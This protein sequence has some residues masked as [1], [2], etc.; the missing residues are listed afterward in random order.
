[1]SASGTFLGCMLAGAGLFFKVEQFTLL[2]NMLA[3]NKILQCWFNQFCIN[4][5]IQGHQIFLCLVPAMV[6]SGILVNTCAFFL[7]Q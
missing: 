1:M 2:P 7:N 4:V 6:L 3:L 5:L